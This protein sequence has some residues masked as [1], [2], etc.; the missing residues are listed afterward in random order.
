MSDPE[1]VVLACKV[2]YDHARDDTVLALR[3]ELEAERLKV[4]WYRHGMHHLKSAMD[5]F[6][7][8]GTVGPHCCCEACSMAGRNDAEDPVPPAVDGVCTFKPAF[9]AVLQ[10][11]GITHGESTADQYYPEPEPEHFCDTSL[12]EEDL[13]LASY[14]RADWRFVGLGKRL[15]AARS[16]HDPELQRFATLLQTLNREPRDSY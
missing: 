8:N 9:E 12:Y 3:R 14:G 2:L 1:R 4:F 5:Y 10:Q 16:V 7:W 6:N 15:W 13:H 11:L